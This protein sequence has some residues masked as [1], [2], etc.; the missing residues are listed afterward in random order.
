MPF[1]ARTIIAL[2]LLACAA[3]SPA[4]AA[5]PAAPPDPPR[6]SADAA[7]L[8]DAS[9]GQ[10]L[11][12]KNETRR[13][14]PAS[15]TKIMTILV[16]LEVADPNDVV[17]ISRLAG[18]W[19]A[20]SIVGLKPGEKMTLENLMRAAALISANDATIAIG[21]HT[22]GNYET[23]IGWMNLKARL[24]G[25]RQTRFAN[26]HGWTHPNHYITAYDMA[27]ITRW[28][29]RNPQ[30][31]RLVSTRQ[32][33]I[34]WEG[35]ERRDE[36]SNTNRLLHSDFPGIDGVKTG[37]TSA[38]GHCLVAS[39]TRNGRR[40]I[41]VVLHSGDRYRDV[42][43]LLEYGFAIPS[44]TVYTCGEEVERVRVREGKRPSVV[45]TA[46]SD[47][48]VYL[49]PD[50]GDLQRRLDLP[51]EVTAPVAKGRSVGEMVFTDHGTYLGRVP[52]VT[53]QAVARKPWYARLA[54]KFHGR[55]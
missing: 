29:L 25:A 23:F 40:L 15:L 44:V 32:A 45:V 5:S 55:S 35:S 51:D 1:A 43:D 12:G 50:R 48:Q 8:I 31:A 18:G 39:A 20:G 2:L 33:T 37:T 4:F 17:T 30:F 36:A 27:L 26:T 54:D 6:I 49:P 47:M 53:A 16:A 34:T 42:A 7:V 13:M 21:E 46:G 11:Y 38:A 52:L 3:I 28:A 19:N 10:I 9:T 24:L 41:A 14:H 22:A